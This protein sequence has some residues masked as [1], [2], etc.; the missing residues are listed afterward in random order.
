VCGLVYS[1][2][3]PS[4]ADLE[5]FYTADAEGGWSKGRGLD[6][7]ETSEKVQRQLEAKR[8][9]T[10][11]LL[12][13]AE[14]WMQL[15]TRAGGQA[16]DFGCGAGAFLD[17]LRERGLETT[18]LEPA[19]FR[20]EAA[21][22]HR[23]VDTIPTDC[24]F[25]VIVI[26]HVLEHLVRPAG[27]LEALATAARP[28]AVLFCS[29]PDLEGLPHHQDFHYVLN[30]VH[31]N[32]FTASSLRHLLQRT[33]WR[34]VHAASGGMIPE[35]TRLM[36]VARRDDAMGQDGPDAQAIGVAQEALRRYGRLL[37]PDGRLRAS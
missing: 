28:G 11:T 32:A 13:A 27:T 36:A 12:D 10:R 29:V 6:A 9:R 16:F 19:G 26:H 8:V 23:I 22:R 34:T 18:G 30:S 14:P 5:R 21:K 24:S 20:A 37:G 3:R 15:A 4:E 31:I 2:P 33:G 7:P 17:I 25:D 35:P 1:S